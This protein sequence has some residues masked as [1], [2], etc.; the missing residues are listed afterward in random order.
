[1]MAENC[2]K[3]K[4]LRRNE[5]SYFKVVLFDLVAL[6]EMVALFEELRIAISQ[7]FQFDVLIIVE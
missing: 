4:C 1:M 6:F 7:H 2:N 3:A 5:I